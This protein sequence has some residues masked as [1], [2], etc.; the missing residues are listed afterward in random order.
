LRAK[1]AGADNLSRFKTKH[2]Q[3]APPHR[4]CARRGCAPECG[5]CECV[6]KIFLSL[7]ASA[8]ANTRFRKLRFDKL[9]VYVNETNTSR[10]EWYKNDY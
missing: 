4:M 1:R 3:D 10:K 6:D 8:L 7:C 5:L 9:G 2:P